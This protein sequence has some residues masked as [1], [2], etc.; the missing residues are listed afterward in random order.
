[1]SSPLTR[2]PA[3]AV[4]PAINIYAKQ[5]KDDIVD[6]IFDEGAVLE[7]SDIISDFIA[8]MFNHLPTLFTVPQLKCVCSKVRQLST[9]ALVETVLTKLKYKPC[10]NQ[11]QLRDLSEFMERIRKEKL[12]K[13]KITFNPL[14]K[15][16]TEKDLKEKEIVDKIE[17]IEEDD[18]SDTK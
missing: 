15:I 11:A 4:I 5:K 7:L 8:D 1:M 16:S 14:P 6:V 12:F 10:Q 9:N 3:P 13:P 2:R 17:D 18:E